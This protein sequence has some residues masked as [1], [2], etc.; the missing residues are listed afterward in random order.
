[1]QDPVTLTVKGEE[2]EIPNPWS[3]ATFNAPNLLCT[4]FHM[5][6][7]TLYLYSGNRKWDILLFILWLRAK[8]HWEIN[9]LNETC[10][11]RLCSGRGEG[12]KK[13][14]GKS[15]TTKYSLYEEEEE[16]E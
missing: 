5:L 3:I 10:E 16:E 8:H 12:K 7:M 14:V 6:Q 9:G 4:E 2:L 1:M 15:L 11:R 13:D